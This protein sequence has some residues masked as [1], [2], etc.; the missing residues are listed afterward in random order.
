[1]NYNSFETNKITEIV[2]EFI[3]KRSIINPDVMSFEM[4]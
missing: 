4:V 2:L 3:H 1:M